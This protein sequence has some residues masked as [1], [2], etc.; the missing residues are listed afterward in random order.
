[1]NPKFE[2]AC[3]DRG[4]GTTYTKIAGVVDEDHE[5]AILT[6][7]LKTALR[8][9]IDLADVERVNDAG[10]RALHAWLD[11]LSAS[12]VAI[13]IDRVS[14]A[15]VARMNENPAFMGRATVRSFF[16]PFYCGAC[17][18]E[19]VHLL[20]PEEVPPEGGKEGGKPPPQVCT[21]C[22]ANAEFDGTSDYFRFI[23]R[24]IGTRAVVAEPAA[25]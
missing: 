13:G 18:T 23:R 4:D 22:A 7:K 8:I 14:S 25:R 12:G 3:H 1:M 10:A 11:E 15:I 17:E 5:L 9:V 2:S 24:I 19:Q 16:A 6:P 20:R 21:E